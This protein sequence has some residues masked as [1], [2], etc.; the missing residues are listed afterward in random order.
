MDNQFVDNQQSATAFVV[1]TNALSVA[2]IIYK[3]YQTNN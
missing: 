1:D 3:M 2:E